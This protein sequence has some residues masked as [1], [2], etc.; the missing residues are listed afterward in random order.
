MKRSDLP[1]ILTGFRFLLVPPVVMLMLNGKFGTALILFA[2][3]GFSDALD[4][5]LARHY[6]WT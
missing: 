2:V 6:H 1:N 5:Y 3:A 4:G